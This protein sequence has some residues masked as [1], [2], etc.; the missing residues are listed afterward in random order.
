MQPSS[1]LLNLNMSSLHFC[2]VSFFFLHIQL[3][4]AISS[5]RPANVK[6]V[7]FH[8]DLAGH[9]LQQS[10]CLE[11]LCLLFCFFWGGV[12]LVFFVLQRAATA[13]TSYSGLDL[14]LATCRSAKPHARKAFGHHAWLSGRPLLRVLTFVFEGGAPTEGGGRRRGSGP[15]LGVYNYILISGGGGGWGSLFSQRRGCVE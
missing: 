5:F 7:A 12:V 10:C 14:A 4:A 1:L 6:I 3:S 9:K 8:G 2:L 11:C 13:K 15:G